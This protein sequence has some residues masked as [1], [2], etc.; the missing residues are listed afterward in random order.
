MNE[1]ALTPKQIEAAYI[2]AVRTA[3]H[4]RKAQHTPGNEG[5]RH[6]QFANNAARRA[7]ILGQQ[8]DKLE[9]R[10]AH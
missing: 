4:C 2:A 8:L 5:K 1:I 6:E 9:A 10:N 3:A 7:T